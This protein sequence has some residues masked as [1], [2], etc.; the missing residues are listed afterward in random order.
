VAESRGEGLLVRFDEQRV[1]QWETLANRSERVQRLRATERMWRHNRGLASL[2][3]GLPTARFVLLHTFAHALINQ[4]ALECGYT[5][6][7]MRERIYSRSPDDGNPMAGV[8][9]YTAAPDAEGTLGGLIALGNPAQLGRIVRE[10]LAR[11]E[12]CSTD[13]FCSEHE[14]NDSE[15][16][17]GH[18][19]ACHSCLFLPETSC[20]HG[21]RHLDRS[22]LVPTFTRSDLAY[23]TK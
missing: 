14:P 5:A 12:L 13:P 20:T 3:V 2:D 23:F 4:F 10:A 16:T 9:I 19:A 1:Q 8:L 7:S 15:G 22:V 21:N 6:A 11:A 17:A 18:G